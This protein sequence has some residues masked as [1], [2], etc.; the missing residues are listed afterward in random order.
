MEKTA[1]FI[2]KAHQCVYTTLVMFRIRFEAD[3]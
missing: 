2:D 3:T 1:I